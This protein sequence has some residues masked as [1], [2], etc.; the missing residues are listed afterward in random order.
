[1]DRYW[2]RFPNSFKNFSLLYFPK[3]G[4]KKRR[5]VV[6]LSSRSSLMNR[7][8]LRRT[9][10]DICL[11]ERRSEENLGRFLV[12][13]P[14]FF[15]FFAAS[16]KSPIDSLCLLILFICLSIHFLNS[17]HASTSDWQIIIAEEKSYQPACLA[18]HINFFDQK[19]ERE[20]DPGWAL[21]SFPSPWLG[22]REDHQE[23]GSKRS[24]FPEFISGDGRRGIEG[25]T[26]RVLFLR[27]SYLLSWQLGLFWDSTKVSQIIIIIK[28]KLQKRTM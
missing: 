2:N 22:A 10:K 16:D 17:V 25:L 8:C 1:M 12:T 21:S 24:C 27:R 4:A 23:R 19:E 3:F 5:C 28:K 15:C 7:V 26:R 6:S 14:T 13:S 18:V 11:N 9:T 20:S